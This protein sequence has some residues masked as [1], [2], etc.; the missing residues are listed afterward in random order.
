MSLNDFLHCHIKQFE[1]FKNRVLDNLIDWHQKTNELSRI[2]MKYS[3]NLEEYKMMFVQMKQLIK[4][5]DLMVVALKDILNKKNNSEIN[6][7]DTIMDGFESCS[8]GTMMD[9]KKMTK[10][11]ELKIRLKEGECDELITY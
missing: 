11:L 7:L 4:N 5:K 2:A 10:L 8:K 3:D 6:T 9:L 1:L